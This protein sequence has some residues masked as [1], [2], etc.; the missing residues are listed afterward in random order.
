MF[1]GK[2]FHFGTLC[3]ELDQRFP[4][5]RQFQSGKVSRFFSRLGANEKGAPKRPLSSF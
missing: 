2:Y 5:L 3:V 1:S 4:I